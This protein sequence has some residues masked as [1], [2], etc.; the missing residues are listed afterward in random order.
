MRAHTSIFWSTKVQ[1]FWP[2]TASLH[3]C[4]RHASSCKM[5][6]KNIIIKL[7]WSN[8]V[9][10][11]Y[12]TDKNSYHVADFLATI[13]HRIQQHFIDILF[14]YNFSV[15]ISFVSLLWLFKYEKRIAKKDLCLN[16]VSDWKFIS[17][18]MANFTVD[19]S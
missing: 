3:V 7:N 1:L 5:K 11:S 15:N 6:E 14:F 17:I 13:L 18:Q 12:T 9:R 10:T 2:P 19:D 16:S 4:M 8:F